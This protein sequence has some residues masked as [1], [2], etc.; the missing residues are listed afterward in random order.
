MVVVKVVVVQRLCI[1]EEEDKEEEK[2]NQMLCVCVCVCAQVQM[3][4]VCVHRRTQD[5]KKTKEELRKEEETVFSRF[6]FILNPKNTWTD[7]DDEDLKE[8]QDHEC[9]WRAVDQSER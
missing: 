8:M 2:K 5:K 3:V 6:H 7:D 9:T 1:S 4:V